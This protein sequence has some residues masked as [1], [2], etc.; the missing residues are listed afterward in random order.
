MLKDQYPGSRVFDSS[1]GEFVNVLSGEVKDDYWI[2]YRSSVRASNY[3]EW[4]SKMH[5]AVM[6]EE[7]DRRLWGK[8]WEVG[9]LVGASVW[10]RRKVLW[11]VRKARVPKARPEF[12]G[13]PFYSFKDKFLLAVYYVVARRGDT[14]TA[15]RVATM[16]CNE[17]GKPCYLSRRKDD[18]EFRKYV[19]VVL[20]YIT[21]I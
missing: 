15:E 18:P 11:F 10:L 19:K 8:V 17:S 14:T 21:H 5:H 20:R 6:V 12:C 1:R 2:V 7:R 13:K 16:P 9:E 3:A 4:K